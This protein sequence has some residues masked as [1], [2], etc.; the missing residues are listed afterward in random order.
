MT[1]DELH[2]RTRAML[3]ALWTDPRVNEC[4]DPKSAGRFLAMAVR[5]MVMRAHADEHHPDEV[6]M[7]EELCLRASAADERDGWAYDFH[8][9]F[10]PPPKEGK[11][12]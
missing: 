10:E 3:D 9:V 2:A 7:I 8:F 6:G 1:E 11:H 12:P 5:G 4:A